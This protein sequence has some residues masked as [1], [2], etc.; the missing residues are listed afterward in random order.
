MASND[1]KNFVIAIGGTGMR[2]LESFVHLCAAGMFD[3]KEIEVLT[4]DTDQEN[5]NK[6]R[7][8]NLV[9][10]YIRIKSEHQKNDGGNPNVKT[11]FSAKINL[12]RFWTDYQ[13]QSYKTL[14]KLSAGSNDTRQENKWL[15]DL[16][17]EE[18]TVQSFDLGHGYRA[19]THLGSHL[20]HHSIL[21]AARNLAEGKTDS[22]AEKDLGK[23]LDKLGAE[24]A[25]SRVFVFGSVFGGTGASSIPVLPN[26]LKE[27]YSI[28]VQ[29][30]SLDLD[31]V[32]FGSTLLTEYF[33]FKKPTAA[34]KSTTENSVIADSAFFALNSQ[35]AL[36]F[37]YSDPTVK[38]RY[39]R[40]Y[41]IGWPT[42][43]QNVDSNKDSNKVITGGSSQK[44]KCH[45]LEL[46][47]AS[48]AFDFF[49]LPTSELDTQKA[50]YLMRS[51]PHDGAYTFRGSDF[52]G[53]KDGDEMEHKLSAFLAFS[54][55]ALAINNGADGQPG[56]KGF[57]Q[58][59]QK[60]NITA[61][62]GLTDEDMSQIDLYLRSFAYR[63]NPSNQ[64]LE[65][66]W[67]YQIRQSVGSGTMMFNSSAFPTSIKDL[68]QVDI[69][70]IMKEEGNQWSEKGL[71]G[72]ESPSKTFDKFVERLVDGGTVDPSQKVTTTKEKF[73]AHIC[74]ALLKS[75]NFQ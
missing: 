56:V 50:R 75:Q 8:E 42:E 10:N 59:L 17:L 68:D 49:N 38:K 45:V 28:M 37:Y 40:F 25:D 1:T 58:R 62:A 14:S 12:Y 66:G 15:S 9:Q 20:M 60:Q 57:N 51:V 46:M 70:S 73:I 4:I 65:H 16:L 32:K 27:A 31:K 44:N 2:C 19:Q 74:N 43:T 21:H 34:D 39:S 47:C 24:S 72:G 26:A 36:Q 29:G 61:Y 11:F 6:N 53:P 69:G 3:N 30:K 48:A 33:S 41:H 35:A 52:V 18:D 7:V 71:F 54:H 23:F 64:E 55:I 63:I 13:E 67:L 5:G 22:P